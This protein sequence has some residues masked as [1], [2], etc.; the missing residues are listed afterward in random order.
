MIIIRNH[1]KKF[2]DDNKWKMK[3]FNK[4]IFFLK[5]LEYDGQ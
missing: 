2:K 1:E 3:F 5:I 4:K